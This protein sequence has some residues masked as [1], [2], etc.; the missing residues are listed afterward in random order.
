VATSKYSTTA[1]KFSRRP[2]LEGLEDRSLPAVLLQVL[3][4]DA[5]G[6][7]DDVR[8][9]GDAGRN[10]VQIQDN[11]AN[12]LTISIDANGD[13]DTT[14]PG[15]LAP[16]AFNFNGDSV[17][18]D[19]SLRGGNDVLNYTATGNYSASTRL[20]TADLGT[21]K[22]AFSFSTGASDVLNASRISLAVVGG[23]SRDAVSVDF[24]EVR[25]SDVTVGLSL[26]AGNDAASADFERIDDGASVDVDVDLGG[27]T[28][29]LTLDF[30]EVGFGDQGTVDVDV[31]GGARK[32]T[33]TLNLHDDV[34]NGV[35]AS[36]LSFEADL[37]AGNDTFRGNLDL[38]SNVFRV[39]DH[40]VAS[41]GVKGGAGN[42]SLS[43]EAVGVN[44]TIKI[45]ADAQLAIDLQGGAGNDSLGMDLILTDSLELIGEV[46]LRLDGGAG[47]DIILALLSNNPNTTGNHDVVILGGQGNDKVTFQ[48][49]NNGG[50]PTFGP[51]GKAVLDGGLGVD[52][53]SNNSKPQ[54]KATGFE[55]VI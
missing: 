34:G 11:G 16:T 7:A 42:D 27:G 8:I 18:L 53:L 4:L 15:D 38:G 5:D 21:G 47:N 26:G 55:L 36:L 32:D 46:R 44:G 25:K 43:V 45:D 14:D 50:A 22:N 39:D 51:T 3:D 13:G 41:I 28:N 29:A 6:A 17:A 37:G 20:L 9:R 40:S 52:V 19:V 12:A 23:T 1:R 48:V 35:S 31:T 24:D 49:F 10:V 30:Q 54:S 2:A 33:V